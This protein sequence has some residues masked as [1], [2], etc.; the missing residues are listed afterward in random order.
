MCAPCEHNDE[1]YTVAVMMHP[2]I[3]SLVMTII[4]PAF[5]RGAR[6]I[7]FQAC[8]LENRTGTIGKLSNLREACM[9]KGG[10]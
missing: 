5:F 3:V 4:F 1:N 10:A 2:F 7:G 9:E 8:E 6:K